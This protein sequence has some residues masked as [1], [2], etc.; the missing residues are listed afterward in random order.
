MGR[1]TNK[2]DLI[3]GA[4]EQYKKLWKLINGISEEDQNKTFAFDADAIGKEAHWKRDK[5]LRD[6]LI[7]LY[8]WHQLLISWVDNNMKGTLKQF[9]LEPYNWKTYGDMNIEFW[10]KHQNTSYDKSKEMIEDSHDKVIKLIEQFSNDELFSK[11]YFKWTGGSTLGQY[12]ISVTSSHYEWA[13]K[14]VK[15]YIKT[16]GR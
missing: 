1:P 12:C 13:M 16:L 10:K 9:L 2:N 7:H 6:V 5:N 11:G 4:N 15:A 8:E 14:K 3:N